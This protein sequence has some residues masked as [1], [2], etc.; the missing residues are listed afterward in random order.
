MKVRV[1]IERGKDGTYSAYM[2]DNDNLPFSLMGDGATVQEAKADFLKAN[3]EMKDLFTERGLKF[4]DDLEFEFSLDVPSFLAYYEGILSLSGLQKVT[5]VAQ[6]QL[7]HYVTG[8]RNPSKKTVAKIQNALHAF[9]KDLSN[10]NL[11]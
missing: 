1:F 3:D 7:S 6:G 2:P 11:L 4:P 10:V 5:G 9:G 8:H